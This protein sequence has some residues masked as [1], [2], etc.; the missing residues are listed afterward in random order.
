MMLQSAVL[1]AGAY[2]VIYQQTSAGIIIAGSI[3]SAR[4]CP[5]RYCDCALARMGRSPAELGAAASG[6]S[7][8]ARMLVGYWPPAQGKVSL[9]GA[10]LAQ[11]APNTLG[12]YVGYLPQQVEL[13]TGTVAQNISR[14]EPEADTE[15]IRAAAATA[16]VHDMIVSLEDGYDTQIASGVRLCRRG[17]PAH[18]THPCALSRSVPGS[19]RRAEL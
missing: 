15:M 3:L 16:G 10:A 11:W 19:S 17:R 8:F 5:H 12:R 2:L 9:D 14:F 4:A 1:G 18:R 13:L 6:K 7:S